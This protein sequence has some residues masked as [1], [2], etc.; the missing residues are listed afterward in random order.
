[1]LLQSVNA[2]A[3]VI[4]GVPLS[5]KFSGYVGNTSLGEYINQSDIAYYSKILKQYEQNSYKDAEQDIEIKLSDIK[6]D[7]GKVSL[8]S[9]QGKDNVLVWDKTMKTISFEVN[10]PDSAL[11]QIEAEYY[12]TGDSS[13]P[14]VR[15]VYID[16]K[17]PFTEATNT[18]FQRMFVDEGEPVI[19]TIGDETRPKQKETPAWRVTRFVDST[20]MA[21]LP[22]KFYLEKG[23]HTIK[24]EYIDEDMALS[25]LKLVVPYNPP[26]YAEV[27]AEYQAKGYK[28]V[29]SDA[30]MDFQAETTAIEKSDPTLRRETNGDPTVKP[31]SIS[32]RKLNVIGGSRWKTG[33]QSITWSFSVKETGLYKIAVRNQ[34]NFNDGLPSY[35][36]IAIDGVVPFEELEEYCFPYERS[37]R[38]TELQSEDG[39]IFE[40]YLTE[41]EHTITM[42]VKYGP[43]TEVMESI[44][45]DTILLS[46]MIMDINKITGNDPDPN[47]D[48][49]FF[50]T[51]PDLE[52]NMRALAASLQ[53]KH[54]YLMEICSTRPAMASNFNTIISQLE[55]MIKNPYGIAARVEELNTAQANL[56]TY[57]LNL[58]AQ[59]L[60]V[61]YFRVGAVS[62]VWKNEKASIFANLY[63]TFMNFLSSFYK[64]YDNVG[65]TLSEDVQIKETI[66]VW[67]ARGTEWAE[68]IKEM[69]DEDFTPKTGIAIKMNVV[70]SSQLSAGNVN[71]IMLSITSGKAPDVAV[72]VDA[73]SPVDFAIR[74]AVEDLSKLNGWDE[75]KGRF[76]EEILV[77]YEY[78]GGVFAIPET[79]D[80]N[81]LFYRKDIMAEL[82]LGVPN[83]REE[84]YKYVL[85]VLYQ[86]GYEFWYSKDFTQILY[87]HGGSFY[88]ED[89]YYSGLDTAEAYNAFVEYCELYTSY[90]CP[91]QADFYNRMRSGEIPIGIGNFS[92]YMKLSVAAPELAGKWGI[93]PL[94]GVLR[95]DGTIDRSA[96]GLTGQGDIILSGTD[97]LESSWEF[98]KWW[99][100][101][102]VQTDF[103]REVEALQGAAA[104]WNTANLA[105]FENLSWKEEDLNVLKEQWAWAK[106]KP[107]VLGGYFTDR[108][109]TNAWTTTV[110]SGGDARDALEEAV[111][112]INRELK[113]KQEE[114]GIFV[115]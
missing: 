3:D 37:W 33:A 79:M 49:E 112:A 67:V 40:F 78:E 20:G 77:P 47:Y 31:R 84:L 29:S 101:E 19:N 95:E 103:A 9:Y 115:E 71:A 102:S 99:S 68:I 76:I 8:T 100:S 65:G 59:Q 45:D 64:D 62:E 66:E 35:R 86:N 22:F 44:N 15:S 98:L 55:S 107:N 23:K 42:T 38:L 51:I 18:V 87:Q 63:T 106:E 30:T 104:R 114:Y 11:Y 53:A 6:T 111:K 58:Q 21:T 61:D 25:Y 89:G 34:Q 13:N 7:G 41:G 5:Q 36:Q 92:V 52:E 69:A 108:Y 93:A 72:G 110:I 2:A 26:A 17:T 74:D 73:T 83:T 43:M 4:P 80:F 56:G 75:V 1:M 105:A 91:T 113:M 85:P 109:I 12:V 60:T 96:G 24:I 94:P 16:G 28:A 88:T 54:D 10:I 70:P 57:Y 39:E 46:S 50:E 48:Y 27:K 14:A 97:K 90:G 32:N 81:V 82:N